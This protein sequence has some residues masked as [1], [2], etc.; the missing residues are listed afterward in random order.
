MCRPRAQQAARLSC[1]T[2]AL[3]AGCAPGVGLDAGRLA[4]VLAVGAGAMDA[5]EEGG[6]EVGGGVQARLAAAVGI[7]EQQLLVLGHHG[8]S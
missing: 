3:L 8:R 7:M 5:T 2:T 1:E 6:A 4:E